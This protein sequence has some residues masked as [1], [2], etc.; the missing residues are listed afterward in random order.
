MSREN[1]CDFRERLLWVKVRTWADSHTGGCSPFFSPCCTLDVR[2]RLMLMLKGDRHEVQ[3]GD[4]WRP[5]RSTA[6]L[7]Y[8]PERC[9]SLQ[10]EHQTRL[11]TAFLS[12]LE[13]NSGGKSDKR[14]RNT[15]FLRLPTL[16]V[17]C[18]ACSEHSG[19]SDSLRSAL[20]RWASDGSSAAL[21]SRC[22]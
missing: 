7:N 2:R 17:G 5:M 4:G 9:D 11:G 14:H 6:S 15:P 12:T 3:R 8:E 20:R 21:S 16:G 19:Q 1:A 13:T 10:V 22:S 18:I